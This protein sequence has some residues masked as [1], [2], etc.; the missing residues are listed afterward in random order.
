MRRSR[1]ASSPRWTSSAS[2][3]T[4]GFV[5]DELRAKLD[6]DAVGGRRHLA[7]D[8]GR[9]LRRPRCW[10]S[11][12]TTPPRRLPRH[13]GGAAQARRRA[14]GASRAERRRHG[15]ARTGL[16]AYSLPVARPGLEAAAPWHDFL[17]QEFERVPPRLRNSS[18]IVEAEHQE[19]PTPPDLVIDFL[20]SSR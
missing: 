17:R 3:P 13:A 7:G 14:G 16:K 1:R 20:D 19:L 10:P 5:M 11:M 15:D 12:S 6:V 9:D 8:G 18:T 4:Q 2:A